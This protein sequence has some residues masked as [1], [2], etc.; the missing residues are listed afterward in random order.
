MEDKRLL[1]LMRK[2]PAAGM[3]QLINQYAGLIC[4]VVRAKLSSSFYVSSDIEECAADVFSEFYISL[5]KYDPE[6]SS[7]KTYLCVLARNKA[8][9]IFRKYSK[10]SI[11]VSLD[12]EDSFIEAIDDISIESELEVVELRHE[13][14]KNVKELGEPDT[15]IIIR[16]YYLGQ[17][18]KE[19]AESLGLSV[20]NIDTRTHRA[21]NK[22]REL[23]GGVE[24]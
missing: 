13:V 7:I 11:G 6:I 9:D 22:L 21:L 24:K 18:S 4:A 23:L 3:E 1:Q 20:S 14:L 10:T 17:S 19:I 2:D 15:S 12:D 8:T 5:S 16:K